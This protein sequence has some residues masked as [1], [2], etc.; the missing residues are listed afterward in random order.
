[1]DTNS[2][3]TERTTTLKF[4]RNRTKFFQPHVT[5]VTHLTYL[6]ALP[7]E[8]SFARFLPVIKV[9]GLRSRNCASSAI[10]RLALLSSC[11]ASLKSDGTDESGPIRPETFWTATRRSVSV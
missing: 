7:F 2:E 8:G 4:A 11:R 10:E 9:F 6:T 5:L 1:M 3:R